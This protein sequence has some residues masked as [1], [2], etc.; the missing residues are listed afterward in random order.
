MIE[1]FFLSC[2]G[3]IFLVTW[4]RNV[5]AN[6]WPQQQFVISRKYLFAI[7]P[8]AWPS[9]YLRAFRLRNAFFIFEHEDC[10]LK[11]VYR[12][13]IALGTTD[14]WQIIIPWTYS[15]LSADPFISLVIRSLHS[16]YL[17]ITIQICDAYLHL[18]R[19]FFGHCEKKAKAWNLII[20]DFVEFD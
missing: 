1:I 4:P 7:I 16:H 18:T 13:E 12:P 2:T 14:H 11:E 15:T 10:S 9:Y 19:T 20:F 3:G 6:S 17:L 5:N 8:W